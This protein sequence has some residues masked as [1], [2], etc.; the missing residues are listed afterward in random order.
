MRWC[1]LG[2]E[3]ARPLA[4]ASLA[5]SGAALPDKDVALGKGLGGHGES[6]CPQHCHGLAMPPEMRRSIKLRRSP[7]RRTACTASDA[8]RAFA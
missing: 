3:G 2:W 7:V 1:I 4:E 5:S 8:A 6:Q